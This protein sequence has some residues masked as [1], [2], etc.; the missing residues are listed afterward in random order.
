MRLKE[1]TAKLKGE[2]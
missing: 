1:L 2:R